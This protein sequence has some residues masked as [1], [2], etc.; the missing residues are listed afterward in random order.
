MSKITAAM[1]KDL[2][3]Q[4]GAPMMAC[5]KALTETGGDIEAAVEVLRK[6]GVASAQKRSGRVAAEGVVLIGISDDKTFGVMTEVNCETDFVA[7]EPQFVE[8]VNALS[9]TAVA[10]KVDS[11]EALMAKISPAGNTFEEQRVE[12]VAKIGENIQVRRIVALSSD[13]GLVAGYLHGARIGVMAAIS[14]KNEDL[15]KDVAMHIAATNP[16]AI[17][18]AGISADL[19]AKEK[20]IYTEQAKQSG[21]PDEIIEKMVS[22]RIKK[23]LKE[24]TLVG[25]PF[26]K[27]PD[28]TVAELLKKNDDASVLAYARFAVGEG[29]EKEEKDFA[30]EVME[31]LK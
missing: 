20:E 12:L 8:F 21:K 10:D 29:I 14:T 16:A 9:A 31:Q 13:N 1:V 6:A 22:G 23:F 3:E 24:N 17:D 5:K 7:K 19:L 28:M 18:E 15:G 4:S 27:D 30:A 11:V 2:R 25:Q 26:V